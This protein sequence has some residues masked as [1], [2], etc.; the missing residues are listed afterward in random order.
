MSL[1]T[2][3]AIFKKDVID[4]SKNYQIVLMVLTPIILS[5]LFSNVMSGSRKQTA[6]PEIGVIS[7]PKQPLINSLTEKGLGKKIVFFENRQ[8]LESAILEGKVR[9]GIILPEV[10]ST[11]TEF[12]GGLS[13]VLLYPPHIPDFG[14]ESLK[15]AFESE[16]R[17]QLH[18]TPPP[19]PFE[20]KTEAVSGSNSKTGSLS[21]GMFP[22][23][24]LMSMGM[25]GFLALPMA[26][27]EE[28]E[29]GTLNAVF[30]TPVKTSE[31]ILG[32]TFFSFFLAL[33]TILTILTI[34]GKWGDN[35]I[36]LLCFVFMGILMTIFIGLIISL[37]AKSQG[38]VN[39]VG[40]TLFL[41]FQM[42]PSLQQSSE[43]I[44]KIAPII[45][46]TYIFSG[47]RKTLFLDL[48]KVDINSDI[49]TVAGL[50]CLTYFICFVLFK[51][52]K[53]DK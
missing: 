48:N 11:R 35:N 21:D 46:S 53:A 45:P 17:Q 3:F 27:V 16:I 26:I 13:V 22:M 49:F 1:K 30:L 14:I 28:R 32:K 33:F 43:I 52:K 7:S 6:L 19:L 8:Q 51:L 29:K 39:A 23:L 5:L 42:I 25:I 9:F 4:G 47:V 37:F 50:T 12:K 2:I 10:I 38:S 20:F 24:I 34:N 18:L 40:T 44:A 31:F 41:F 36:L 15:T